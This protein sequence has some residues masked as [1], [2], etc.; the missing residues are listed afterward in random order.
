MSLRRKAVY[1]ILIAP[2]HHVLSIIA[3]LPAMM[4]APP[5]IL[6]QMTALVPLYGAAL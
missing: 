3:A 6:I 1:L 4:L 5:D 2:L